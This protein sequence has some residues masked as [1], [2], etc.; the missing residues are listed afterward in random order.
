[1]SYPSNLVVAAI[2]V[3]GAAAAIPAQQTDGPRQDAVRSGV[4]MSAADFRADRLVNEVTCGGQAQ[5]KLELHDFLDKPYI[6][7]THEGQ[8]IR[9]EKSQIFGVRDCDGRTIH[10]FR[11]ADYQVAEAGPIVIYETP[12]Y[13]TRGFVNPKTTRYFFSVGLEGGVLPLTKANLKAAFA[14]NARFVALVDQVF[15]T[16]SELA[17]YDKL[18]RTYRVNHVLDQAKS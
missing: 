17:E 4:F 1:M 8:R 2:A 3:L 11:N 13:E 7:V 14:Q 16:D 18:H 15:A 5:H 12:V 6:H 10:F 9:Y